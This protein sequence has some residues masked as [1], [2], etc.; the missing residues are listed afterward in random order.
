MQDEEKL[1][2][3]IARRAELTLDAAKRAYQAMKSIKE[4]QHGHT[5]NS[6]EHLLN[7]STHHYA[8]TIMA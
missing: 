5:L 4:Q 1:I 6:A 8:K 3:E 2:Q 7:S